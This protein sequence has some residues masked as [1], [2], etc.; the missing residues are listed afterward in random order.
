MS[1][2]IS[3]A[4]SLPSAHCL[5]PTPRVPMSVRVGTREDLPFMDALQKKH[6]KALGF[7]P[8]AQMEG[9]IDGG[10]VLVAEEVDGGQSA[11]G[12]ED[13]N[14][15]PP[16]ADRRPR[17]PV[18]YIISKDRYLKRDE[19]GAVFQLCVATGRE[20]G[21]I[22]ANLLR[23]VFER[24]A[25]GCRL[26]CCW[27]AQ[28][29]PANKFW[30]AMGF[31]PIAYRTG[32]RRST[33]GGRRRTIDAA[34]DAFHR[35]PQTADRGPRIHI[36]WQK[37]IRAG[38]TS[39][40]WWFPSKT[41]GGALSAERIVLPIPPGM[42]WRD[43]LPVLLPQERPE[44]LIGEEVRASPKQKKPQQVLRGPC[45]MAMSRLSFVKTPE[46][47]KAKP[48]REKRAKAKHDPKVIAKARELRDRWMEHVSANGVDPSAG[49]YEVARRI[50]TADKA[51][52]RLAA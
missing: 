23:E 47:E 13:E 4:S 49:K 24:S 51:I 38:D 36:F 15:L 22:G 21:F 29:L 17:T 16:T 1:E 35:P 52:P 20:R 28:D 48:K 11:V 2:I 12:G 27:C 14:V 34:S 30:E 44:R 6:S 10:N 5:L 40:P 33:V 9:Y 46:E 43:A 31:V 7:F 19:L 18:G 3:S 39:T 41:T 50:E 26:Y 42:H 45:R 37:R 8:R 25:Y 32:G